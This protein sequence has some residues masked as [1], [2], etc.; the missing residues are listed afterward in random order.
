MVDIIVGVIP[1]VQNRLNQRDHQRRPPPQ[2][3]RLLKDKRK[4]EPD[5]PPAVR[6]GIVVTLSHPAERR[7]HP[8]RPKDEAGMQRYCP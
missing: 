1:P 3:K 2:K 4:N 8:D 7:K 5:R 6:E